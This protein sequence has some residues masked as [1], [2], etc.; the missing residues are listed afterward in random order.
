MLPKEKVKPV[1]SISFKISK[2]LYK[3]AE[4]IAKANN[5]SIGQYAKKILHGCVLAALENMKG[6]K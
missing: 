4:E 3:E 1:K 6:S 5:L 2:A